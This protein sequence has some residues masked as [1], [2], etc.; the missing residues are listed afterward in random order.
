[1]IRVEQEKEFKQVETLV[2]DAFWNLYTP[3]ANEHF[4]LHNIR[5]NT[6][7]IKE[8]SLVALNDSDSNE[9]IGQIA[10]TKSHILQHVN[11][12][13]LKHNVITFGPLSVASYMQGKGIGT[14]LVIDSMKLA[15]EMGFKVVV[16]YGYP[17]YYKRFGFVNGKHFG[18]SSSNGSFPK[19]LLVKELFAG[20][21]SG[22]CGKFFESKAFEDLNNKSEKCELFDKSFEFK[23]KFV[24]PSQK[25]FKIMINLKWNDPGPVGLSEM[26]H[27]LEEIY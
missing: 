18:I 11:G 4:I 16:I 3:G 24:T 2:R 1:M 9:I 6:D 23:E 21:L 5:G 25:M 20:G 7:F 26:C 10:Y 8:L 13:D 17:N 19:S 15:K 22:I 14:R 12:S 27:S